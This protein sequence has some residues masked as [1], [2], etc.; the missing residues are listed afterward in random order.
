MSEGVSAG[1][2]ADTGQTRGA[3]W[4]GVGR[5]SGISRGRGSARD[6]RVII[7]LVLIL[8]AYLFIIIGG[9]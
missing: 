5:W 3:I 4:R 9:K 2:G 8:L 1:A 7:L 6:T